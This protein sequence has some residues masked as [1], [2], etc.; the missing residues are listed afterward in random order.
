MG[1]PSVF[2]PGCPQ[3]DRTVHL[4]EARHGQTADQGQCRDGEGGPGERRAL[5]V[6]ESAEQAEVDEELADEAVQRRQA[7][8]GDRPDQET[9]GRPRHRLRQPAQVVDLAGVGRMDDRAGT[10]EQQGLE[11]RVV[12]DVQQGAAQA[13][14]DPIRAVQR[15][16]DQRQAQAHD[17]DADVLDAVIGQESLQ[18]VLADGKGNPQDAGDHA[19]SQE[20]D[21]PFQR[22]VREE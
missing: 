16:A 21:A 15:A 8:D 9:D 1:V 20:D 13:E 18:V 10:Q 12:P 5:P 6:H 17:D 4:H 11:Q 14:D 7:A 22:G 19:Q 2:R 3:E